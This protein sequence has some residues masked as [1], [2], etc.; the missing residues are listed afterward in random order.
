MVVEF[1][2]RLWPLLL[3]LLLLMSFRL[4]SWANDRVCCCACRTVKIA[5]VVANI[6]DVVDVVVFNV[7]TYI[8]IRLDSGVGGTRRTPLSQLCDQMIIVVE[9][10]LAIFGCCCCPR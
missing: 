2:R 3:L 1:L 6:R 7:S 5:L 10:F 4:L 8:T 9:G